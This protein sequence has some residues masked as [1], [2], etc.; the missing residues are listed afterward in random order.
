MVNVRS[1]GL[2][3]SCIHKTHVSF[4]SPSLYSISYNSH[5]FLFMTCLLSSYKLVFLQNPHR[6]TKQSNNLGRTPHGC[7]SITSLLRYCCTTRSH[8]C[9]A[10]AQGY[11]GS[12]RNRAGRWWCSRRSRRFRYAGGTV[13]MVAV[14]LTCSSCSIDAVIVIMIIVVVVVVV[15]VA[16]AV[17]CRGRHSRHGCRGFCSCFRRMTGKLLGS[18]GCGGLWD[19][20]STVPFFLVGSHG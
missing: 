17:G 11:T 20:A 10:I 7:R 8:G 5:A 6:N 19:T 3:F 13:P 2:L 1:Q 14:G 9:R 18:R 4:C 16:V 12:T 15:V